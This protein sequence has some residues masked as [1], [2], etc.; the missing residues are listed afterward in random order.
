MYR[1]IDNSCTFTCEFEPKECAI[2][3]P[4][5]YELSDRWEEAKLMKD[6]VRERWSKVESGAE[7]VAAEQQI[8]QF[9]FAANPPSMG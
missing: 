7:A 2:T 4:D 8:A 5:G 9:T 6:L 1:I 3:G